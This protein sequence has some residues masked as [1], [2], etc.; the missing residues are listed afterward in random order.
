VN[1][2]N[3]SGLQTKKQPLLPGTLQTSPM[4]RHADLVARCGMNY[5]RF[6]GNGGGWWRAGTRVPAAEDWSLSIRTQGP[7]LAFFL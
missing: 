2:V 5:G 1:Y 6:P 7:G 4:N 3:I